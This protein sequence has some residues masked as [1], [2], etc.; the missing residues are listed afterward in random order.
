[1]NSQQS[2]ATF[3]VPINVFIPVFIPNQTATAD[4]GN[5]NGNATAANGNI[6]TATAQGEPHNMPSHIHVDMATQ[7][8]FMNAFMASLA[9]QMAAQQAAAAAQE[10][11]KLKVKVRYCYNCYRIRHYANK[12]LIFRIH[13]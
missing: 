9:A 7:I 8:A 4:N 1:M 12:T 13:K 10:P 2:V 3:F 5:G 6:P 11:V